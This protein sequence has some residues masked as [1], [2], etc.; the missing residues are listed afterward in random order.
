MEKITDIKELQLMSNT[1]RQDI[2]KM[3]AE[4]GS[5]HSAG[6]LGLADV[7]AALY[8]NILNHNPK[9]PDWDERDRFILSN[10]HVCPVWYAALARS[11]YF[12][13]EELMT[14]RKL[15]SRLEGHPKIHCAPGV[16]NSAGPLGQGI[17]IAAGVALAAKMDKKDFKVYCSMGDGEIDEGQ[18][19]EAFMFAAKYKLDNLIGFID[20]NYIQIDGDT[21]EV[22]PLDPLDKKM[23]SFN[24]HVIEVDGNDMKA[25]VKAFEE[26]RAVKEK[27]VCIIANTVPGKCISFMEGKAGWHGKPPSKEEEVVALKELEEQRKKLEQG[28]D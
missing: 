8:F 9:K 27:P 17:S 1:I 21:E 12:P 6:P 16:E 14:L 4:A 7:F 2:I 15:N 26:A 18:P 3:L 23:E 13:V 28:A 11:G 10:G 20:R 24:W 22:M 19:W 25:T 5:G